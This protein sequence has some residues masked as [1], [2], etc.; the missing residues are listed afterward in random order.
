MTYKPTAERRAEIVQATL[1]ILAE[2]GLHAWT[3]AALARRVGVA[4]A[5]IFRHFESKDEILTEALRYAA[6]ELRR[7]V[8]RYEGSGE[9]WARIEGL[10]LHVLSYIKAAGGAPLIVLTGQAT[11][12][13]PAVQRDVEA[14]QGA[15]RARL[16]SLF[17][18][19]M[20]DL[21]RSRH[22]DPQVLA[23]LAIAIGQGTALRWLVSGR[24]MPLEERA[25]AMLDVLRSCLQGRSQR[26]RR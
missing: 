24:R 25:R 10:L 21:P 26:R 11:R 4:E 7:H 15:V 23:D 1:A 18:E 16:V 12:M 9:P 6:G 8:Q 13:S 14:T 20:A 22:Q 19:A 17:E 2:E 3:T 5:T